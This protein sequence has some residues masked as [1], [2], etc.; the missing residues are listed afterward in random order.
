MFKGLLPSSIDSQVQCLL[1]TLAYWHALAKLRQHTSSTLKKLSKA[2]TRLGNE[3]R[4]FKN[5]TDSMEVYET[6]REASARQRQAAT[7]AQHQPATATPA[8]RVQKQLNL[9]TPKFHALGDYVATIA[10]F[11]TTDSFSTQTV[12]LSHSEFNVINIC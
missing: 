7:K 2:T 6:P 10:Q 4:E 3:L 9:N 5:A 12:G 8:T 1:F 11:G